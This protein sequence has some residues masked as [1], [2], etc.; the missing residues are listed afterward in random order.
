VGDFGTEATAL[1]L[2]DCAHPW[3]LHSAHPW[4]LRWFLSERPEAVAALATIFM[5]EV[6]RLVRE[7]AGVPPTPDRA[8][9]ELPRIGAVSFLHRERLGTQSACPSAWV[10]DRRRVLPECDG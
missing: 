9:N 7:A 1:T 4:R 6:E 3:R 2:G 10:R 8:D 5:S